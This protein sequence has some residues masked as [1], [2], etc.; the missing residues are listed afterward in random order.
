MQGVPGHS[1]CREADKGGAFVLAKQLS[2]VEW[3]LVVPEL[4]RPAWG[5]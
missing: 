3:K 2:T 4:A 5:E 1:C